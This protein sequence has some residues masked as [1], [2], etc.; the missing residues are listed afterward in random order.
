MDNPDLIIEALLFASP[1]P[2]TQ[3]KVNMLFEDNPPNLEIVSERLSQRYLMQENAF[4]IQNVA[5]GYQLR[6]KPEYD[7]YVRRLLNKTG[8]LHLTQAALEA[9]AI[10]AYR[11]PISRSDIEAIRGVDSSGVLKTLLKKSL[12]KIKGRDEGPGRPLMY[13]TTD[14]FLQAFGLSRLAELPKL[15]EVADLM[16]DQPA[17]TEQIDAFK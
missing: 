2:L 14:E 3:Q 13:S 9:L 11:Q 8:Q 10:V 12:I 5:G 15:K 6:T 16:E 17:L 4:E 7:L 1:E